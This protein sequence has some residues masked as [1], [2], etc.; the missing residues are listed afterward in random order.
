MLAGTI[1]TV[2]KVGRLISNI[3]I[4]AFIGQ[5]ESAGARAMLQPN[6]MRNT[7][8]RCLSASADLYIG[9]TRA[10]AVVRL[11]K[12][13][14]AKDWRGPV[15]HGPVWTSCWVCTAR[16]S[17]LVCKMH[18]GSVCYGNRWRWSTNFMSFAESSSFLVSH[19]VSLCL[20]VLFDRGLQ[21]CVVKL[22]PARRDAIPDAAGL[23]TWANALTQPGFQIVCICPLT[24]HFL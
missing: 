19:V 8:V 6:I 20:F 5:R 22:A 2:R 4:H 13:C 16:C 3:V 18:V 17:C 11:S 10:I 23:Q 7:G 12:P 9:R 1:E 24:S 15:Q 14:L 21:K